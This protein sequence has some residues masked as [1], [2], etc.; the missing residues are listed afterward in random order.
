MTDGPKRSKKKPRKHGTGIGTQLPGQSAITM[1]ISNG[2]AGEWGRQAG[3]VWAGEVT[4]QCVGA[5]HPADGWLLPAA[6]SQ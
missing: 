2:I 1:E 4:E 3:L 6:S 5:S